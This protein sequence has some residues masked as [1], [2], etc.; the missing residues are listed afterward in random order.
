MMHTSLQADETNPNPIQRLTLSMELKLSPIRPH[1]LDSIES[2]TS[3][4]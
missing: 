1:A 4:I 2:E 3:H